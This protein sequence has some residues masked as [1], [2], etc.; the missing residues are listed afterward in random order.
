MTLTPYYEPGGITIVLGDCREILPQLEATTVITDPVW[1]NT[2][3]PLPGS[4]RPKALYDEMLSSLA[5]CVVRLAVQLGC[6]SEPD[7]LAGTSERFK[8]FRVCWLERARPHYK[9]RLLAG[10]DIAYLYGEPPAARPGMH[11]IPGR[12]CSSDSS[13]KLPGHPCARKLEHVE[14]L[15]DKWSEPGELICDPFVGSGTTLLA[16]KNME[17]RA[18]GIEIEEEYCELAASRLGQEVLPLAVQ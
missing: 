6:D 14:W 17:R 2:S 5:P 10:T 8:F 4:D 9:G 15:V 12:M 11:L 13:G 16:A 18:I 3:I 7:F 1:P